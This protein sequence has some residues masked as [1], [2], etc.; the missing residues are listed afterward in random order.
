MVCL[1]CL[2]ESETVEFFR[3]CFSKITERLKDADT[4]DLVAAADLI[5]GIGDSDGKVI[6]VGNGGSA[7][8]ASHL[9]VDL[10]KAA[11]IRAVNFNEPSLLTC[12][13]NDYG[14][15]HWVAKALEFYADPGD[16]AVLISSSGASQNIVNGAEQARTMGLTVISLSGFSPE[17]PLRQLG[18][19][20]LF[21][22]SDSYNIVEMTHHV[23][24]L[25][26]VDYLIETNV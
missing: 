5:R 21:A 16:L 1:T 2:R 20:N 8:I 3:D 19:L 14:Y 15:E 12:F 6:V 10:T 24:L 7:A 26:I 23:W 22:A 11:G 4:S 9:T 13:A 18:D 17:N 25:A